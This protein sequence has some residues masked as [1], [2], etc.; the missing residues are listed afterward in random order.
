MTISKHETDQ[1]F[2]V[3]TSANETYFILFNLHKLG[4]IKD[5]ILSRDIT[6]VISFCLA[7]LELEMQQLRTSSEK[8]DCVDIE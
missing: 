2:S 1:I 8:T 4:L 7:S 5:Q 3:L 6:K